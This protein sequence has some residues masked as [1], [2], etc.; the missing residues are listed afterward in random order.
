MHVITIREQQQTATGFDATVKFDNRADEYPITISDPFTPQEEQ[1][2]EWY[3]EEWLIYPMLDQVKAKRAA[4][5]V[6]EYGE[7][8]FDQI[9][10]D[11]KVY[12]EYDQLKDDLSQL[13]IEIISKT[14]EFQGLHWEALK[15]PDLPR[16]L[17]VDC[18]M[19]RKTVKP[20]A[21]SAK[22]KESPV[23][24][25]LVVTI[26]CG[27]GGRGRILLLI[28]SILVMTKKLGR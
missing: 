9:F 16:P 2:L 5:S 8:L 24:N 12:S 10:A 14:P 27:N 7:K 18:V 20:T 23:I 21:V 22:V 28:C 1:E 11:R 26:I 17:A 13:K 6:K 4:A 25:L 3:F 15:H 19:L